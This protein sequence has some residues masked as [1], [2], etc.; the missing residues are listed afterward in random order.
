MITGCM[1]GLMR[2][3]VCN[4][5]PL[6]LKQGELYVTCAL[7][8]SLAAVLAGLAAWASGLALLICAATGPDL[9]RRQ[10]CLWLAA[11][12]L[13]VHSRRNR[14]RRSD[15]R[16][17]GERPFVY[18]APMPRTRTIPDDQVFAVS[19]G[20]WTRRRQGRV[21]PTRRRRHRAC[22][23]H[24][25][26]ALWQPRRHGARRPACCLGGLEH[27][28]PR[29]LPR[30]TT[31]ARRR[32]LKAIGPVDPP[33]LP[34]DLRDP[35][36]AQRAAAWRATVE[37][38]LALRLGH[39]PE[40]AGNGGAAVC[41]LAGSGSVVPRLGQR[42]Q[43]EGCGQAA[44]LTQVFQAQISSSAPS[45]APTNPAPIP[46]S[47]TNPRSTSPPISAPSTPSAMVV[48]YQGQ[49]AGCAW[50]ETRPP[51]QRSAAR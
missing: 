11:A 26:A 39:G 8:G 9:A 7:A 25:G 48:A 50:P 42:L 15:S 36:L 5:V 37:S 20:F 46:A 27:R 34:S 43:T 32:L 23:A 35:D 2:D 51:P 3:V 1:G 44:Y 21:L 10:H 28:P 29:P 19:S 16:L 4:E 47:I 30:P 22:P 45:S 12:G 33:P 6:V 40:G 49:P 31:R 38:A 13:P 17:Q 14:A 18:P 24:A 41:G